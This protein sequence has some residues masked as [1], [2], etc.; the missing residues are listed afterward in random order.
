MHLPP[1]KLGPLEIHAFGLLA[2]S[3]LLLGFYLAR[4]QTR[5]TA[6]PEQ[7]LVEAE[8]WLAAGL[9]VGAHLYSV[10]IDYPENLRH[11]W[12]IVQIWS[13][14]SSFGGLLGIALAALVFCRRR[15]VPLGAFVDRYAAA[16]PAAWAVGRLG[17]TL[18]F[19]H[20]GK[21]TGF[22]LAMEYPGSAHGISAGLRHNLGLYE[23]LLALVIAAGFW[24][25]ARRPRREGWYTTALIL[26]YMPARFALDFLRVAERS[27]HGFTD[28]QMLCVLFFGFG[29]HQWARARTLSRA[30]VSI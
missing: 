21:L 1:L 17:C 8:P 30:S 2:V 14:I 6:L 11:P 27:Y 22:P 5:G 7:L 10:F 13:G 25:A 24:W 23:A 3:S 4:K 18:A 19:D 9:F 12:V 15:D 26:V 20:P 29:V 16:F 28:E